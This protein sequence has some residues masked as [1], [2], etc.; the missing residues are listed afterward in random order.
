M[1]ISKQFPMHMM[2]T[3][4]SSKDSFSAGVNG[5]DSVKS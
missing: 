3:A 1:G 4:L 2:N 5:F